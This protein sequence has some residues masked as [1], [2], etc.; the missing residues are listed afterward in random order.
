MPA[1]TDSR[2]AARAAPPPNDDK[3]KR[4]REG[5]YV[6]AI[7][8]GFLLAGGYLIVRGARHFFK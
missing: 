5:N 4:G 8:E 2:R 7:G 6:R 3:M 1:A